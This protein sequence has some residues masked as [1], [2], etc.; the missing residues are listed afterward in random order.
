MAAP[1]QSPDLGG[2][3]A[4]SPDGATP[5][6]PGAL[7]RPGCLDRAFAACIVGLRHF[8]RSTCKALLPASC[9]RGLG[10]RLPA[11]G[12]LTIAKVFFFVWAA[13][14][15][16]YVPFTSLFFS[17]RGLSAGE[18]GAIAAARPFVSIVGTPLWSMVADRTGMHRTMLISTLIVSTVLLV[19]MGSISMDYVSPWATTYFFFMGMASL[20]EFIGS[21]V[22]PLVDNS[23]MDL[24]GDEPQRYGEVRLWAGV[25]YGLMA[26]A[27]GFVVNAWGNTTVIWY[28][29]ALLT[30]PTVALVLR[31]RVSTPH[32]VL[33]KEEEH[34]AKRQSI[35]EEGGKTPATLKGPPPRPPPHPNTQGTFMRALS[36]LVLSPAVTGVFIVA[37]AQGVGLGMAGSFESLRIIELGGETWMVGAAVLVACSAEVIVMNYSSALIQRFN[38]G[39]LVA[40]SSLALVGRLVVYAEATEAWMLLAADL[41]HSLTWGLF[42][43]V[44]INLARKFAPEGLTTTTIALVTAVYG[45]IGSAVGNAV[46]G[47][48]FAVDGSRTGFLSAAAAVAVALLVYLLIGAISGWDVAPPP[49]DHP[50]GITLEYVAEVSVE[51]DEEGG[52]SSGS[53]SKGGAGYGTSTP[54]PSPSPVAD[55]T[56]A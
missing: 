52:A 48:I 50:L 44:I 15:A 5:L 30:L 35:H 8:V 39:A 43:P 38:A 47:N 12:R 42:W 6:V 9:W 1:T 10:K 37:F 36:I 25:G 2:T 20:S 34:A 22:G 26:F 21:P 28:L 11:S 55:D 4:P 29:L 27:A 54:T 7:P 45:G 14:R 16:A 56:R 18:I 41:S 23:V 32:K 19:I 31:F 13:S 46:F 51:R 24:L 40:V 53:V 49:K 33:E 3:P 17:E